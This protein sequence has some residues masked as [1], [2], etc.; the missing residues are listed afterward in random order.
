[1]IDRKDVQVTVHE[2]GGSVFLRMALARGG[3]AGWALLAAN[4]D[5][6]PQPMK[7]EAELEKAYQESRAQTDTTPRQAHACPTAS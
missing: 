5:V 1:M 2:E 3:E 7:R 4:G 6:I